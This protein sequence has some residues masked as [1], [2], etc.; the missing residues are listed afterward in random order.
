VTTPNRLRRRSGLVALV[1]FIVL[2]VALPTA[3]AVPGGRTAGTVFTVLSL[4]LFAVLLAALFV[5]LVEVIRDRS[6]RRPQA[7]GP[8]WPPPGA[9]PAAPATRRFPLR[10]V[11]GIVSLV[12]LL[13]AVVVAGASPDTDV[14]V[15][16][17]VLSVL[18][19]LLAGVAFVALLIGEARAVQPTRGGFSKDPS[20]YL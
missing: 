10:R 2:L 3:A 6:E 13:I 9:T 8:P 14:S 7:S 4:L 17:V 15:T 11:C 1:S 20:D 18:T 16:V 12:A 5:H 19:F